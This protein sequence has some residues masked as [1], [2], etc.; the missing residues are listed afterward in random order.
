MDEEDDPLRGLS[1]QERFACLVAEHVLGARAQAWD[2]DGRQAAVDAV[3]TLADGRKASFEVTSLAASGALQTDSLLH[4]DGYAWPC[5]GRWW[6]TI[7][8][9]DVR[10]LPRL[11]DVY[12]D[13]ALRCEAAG[14]TRPEQL[15]GGLHEGDPDLRWLVEESSS[16]MV[17]HPDVPCREGDLVR[18]ATVMPSG[19]GGG[20]DTGLTGLR[21]A[22]LDAFDE[23]HIARRI[24]KLTVSAGEER[25]LFIAVHWSA[26]PFSVAY[27][28]WTGDALPP[29]APPLPSGVTH[30]WL[31]GLGQRVLLGDA[32]GWQQHWLPDHEKQ[33]DDETRL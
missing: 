21:Q 27:G 19:R 25:H 29:D 28:L 23:P 14:A 8:V 7:Q 6:W 9:G 18:D 4:R 31:A 10:D 33:D 3:L 20:V 2:T 13:I 12:Q 11:R 26:L 17:G 24:Q 1:Q 16:D 32:E 15:R 30:L 5:P 22:L